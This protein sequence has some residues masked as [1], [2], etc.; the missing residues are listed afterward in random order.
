MQLLSHVDPQSQP[1][2]AFEMAFDER[3][4]QLQ[5]TQNSHR[6]GSRREWQ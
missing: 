5:P 2:W 1:S 4:H 3:I 6:A